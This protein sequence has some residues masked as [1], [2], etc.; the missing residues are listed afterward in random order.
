MF[1]RALTR[2][3]GSS[4]VIT[5]DMAAAPAAPADMTSAMFPGV[6]PPIAYTGIETEE[7]TSLRKGIP[8]G[9]EGLQAVA[10]TCPAMR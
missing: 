9:S 10:N 7:H 1:P 2:A 4:H 5:D 6:T 8:R 3:D